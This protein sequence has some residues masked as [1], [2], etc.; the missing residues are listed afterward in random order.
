MNTGVTQRCSFTVFFREDRLSDGEMHEIGVCI[1]NVAE[2]LCL[3][4]CVTD[5]NLT[6]P[7]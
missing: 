4:D 5:A 7:R 6:S 2:K 1:A 3:A